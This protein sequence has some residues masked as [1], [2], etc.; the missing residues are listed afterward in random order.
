VLSVRSSADD[1][2]PIDPQLMRLDNMLIAEGVAGPENATSSA[3]V[4]GG[5][6]EHSADYSVNLRNIRHNY[7][8]QLTKYEHQCTEFTTHVMN[9]L[10]EQACTRPITQQE[11]DRM[12]KTIRNKFA[13]IQVQL[14]QSTCESI[15]ILRSRFL[16]ARCA[17][18][19]CARVHSL[20]RRKRRN[21]SKQAT[22][23]LNDYFHT[24]LANPYPSEE[25]KEELARKC[26][27][28]VSQVGRPW[29]ARPPARR[30]ATGS[31]TG[32]YG[33]K[34]T[35]RTNS[36]TACTE[37]HRIDNICSDPLS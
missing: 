37:E 19:T 24:H 2:D 17:R 29:P 25:A 21:F 16:D 15:M 1:D 5:D 14:K 22:T 35:W 9:L 23:I 20:C 7:Q 11:I 36:R 31:A 33:T 8:Q 34:R 26:N 12:L 3:V 30:C 6:I 13:A 27:I 28:T 10:R 32:E 4:T 18:C